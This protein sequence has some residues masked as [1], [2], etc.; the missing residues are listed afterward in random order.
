MLALTAFTFE[1]R[2][3]TGVPPHRPSRPGRRS[4]GGRG[5]SH[6]IRSFRIAVAQALEEPATGWLPRISKYPY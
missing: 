1:T 2:D 5:V 6:L 3:A 4:K